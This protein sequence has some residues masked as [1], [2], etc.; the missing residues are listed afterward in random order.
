MKAPAIYIAIALFL[1]VWAWF[2][3]LEYPKQCRAA[4][5]EHITYPYK[6]WPECWDAD[7]TRVF[8]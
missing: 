2:L 8:W 4:G 3:F 6:G 5:G 7:G 1:A